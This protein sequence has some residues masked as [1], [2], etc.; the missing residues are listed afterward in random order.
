MDYERT[1]YP[2]LA[3]LEDDDDDYIHFHLVCHSHD[4]VGWT[5]TPEQYYSERVRLI[6]TNV[7]NA[8]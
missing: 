1:I 4:D 5:W 7:V 2:E 6:I 8:L 3:R